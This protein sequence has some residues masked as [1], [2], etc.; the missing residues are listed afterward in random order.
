MK[1][2][3]TD[4]IFAVALLLIGFS[5]LFSALRVSAASGSYGATCASGLENVGGICLPSASSTPIPHGPTNISDLIIAVLSWLL[6]IAFLIAVT[7]IIVGGILYLTAGDSKR[8]EQAKKVIMNA[9]IGL[10][11]IILSYT[12]VSVVNHT[13]GCVF[14]GTVAAGCG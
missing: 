5:P 8:N 14:T 2:K 1:I 6:S 4:I 12:I 3:T 10:V 13:L 9:V 7:M 11:I